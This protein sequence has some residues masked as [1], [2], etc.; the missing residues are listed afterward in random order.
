MQGRTAL[1]YGAAQ[2][3]GFETARLLAKQGNKVVLAD[4]NSDRL[5][6]A[7]EQLKAE[8]LVAA[9]F[10]VDVSNI[11]SLQK[12]SDFAKDTFGSLDILVDCVG[13]LYTTT[14]EETTPEQ[15][16]K[17]MAIN[18]RSAFFAVQKALPYLKESI[19]P[20]VI[21]ISSVAGRMG[22]FNVSMA[23]SASKGGM[24][25]LG[26][27]LARQLAPYKITVN[28]I[29]PST[30]NGEMAKA[31]TPEVMQ[32]QKDRALLKR[33]AEPEEIAAA[34]AFLASE[35]AGFI[36]GATLDVN[37]SACEIMISVYQR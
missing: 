10:Q 1:V 19:C 3:I 13:I 36:T 26:V 16:D 21:F 30:T 35:D 15:W 33:I 9:D 11:D 17:V 8:G 28:C 32:L 27:G 20:R 2:G 6:P 18:L 12:V 29:C 22:G 23:Y 25:S 34:V 37:G 31:F 14:V 5:K 7:A 4:I 24:L